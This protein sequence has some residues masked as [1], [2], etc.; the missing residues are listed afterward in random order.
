LSRLKMSSTLTPIYNNIKEASHI[1]YNCKLTS[2][3]TLS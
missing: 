1:F 3:A 2:Q